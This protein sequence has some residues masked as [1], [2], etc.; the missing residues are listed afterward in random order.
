MRK[1]SVIVPVFDIED[2]LDRC[3]TSICEQTYHNLEI[4]CV[5]DATLDNSVTIA[6]RHRDRDPRLT[7][8]H[9]ER[10]MG[11]GAARNTGLRYATGDYIKFVDGDDALVPQSVES[12]VAAIERTEADWAFSAFHVVDRQGAL[13]RRSPFH[14]EAMEQAAATGLLDFGGNPWFLNAMWPSAWNPLWRA[15]RIKQTGAWF[16]EGLHFEDH[17]F[18]FTHG[19]QTASAVYLPEPLYIYQADRP[20]QITRDESNRVFDI[21][22][23]IDRLGP[24]FSRHIVGDDLLRFSARNTIRLIVERTWAL[25]K[26]GP[27]IGPFRQKAAD[28]LARYPTDV[29]LDSKDWYIPTEDLALLLPDSRE[30]EV[31]PVAP[32]GVTR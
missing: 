21:F 3:L 31:E 10:N 13:H 23:V 17:E 7:L 25:S 4:I 27:L 29:L 1:V 28:F 5:N 14:T 30:P 24:I 16:P 18:F 6:K 11:L 9:A 20:G 32:A 19:F 26:T 15:A 8:I 2:F 12:L 22:A